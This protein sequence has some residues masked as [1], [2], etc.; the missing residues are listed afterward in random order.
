MTMSW[1]LEL[2]ASSKMP[3]TTLL[4]PVAEII[5]ILHLD[6]PLRLEAG[7]ALVPAI[8]TLS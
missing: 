7:P 1:T 6:S 5:P 4:F 2:T 3:E 8:W